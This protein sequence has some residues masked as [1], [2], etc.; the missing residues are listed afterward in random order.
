M[1]TWTKKKNIKTKGLRSF[2]STKL[3]IQILPG[4]SWSPRSAN[5]P[6]STGKTTTAAQKNLSVTLRT[7]EQRGGLGEEPSGFPFTPRA[8][9][10]PQGSIHKYSWERA[11]LLRVQTSLRVQVRPPL[12]LRGTC[13]EPS[14]HRNQGDACDRSL[15]FSICTQN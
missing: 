10:L 13:P 12:L 3:H 2:R 5:K 6:V 1:T 9:H 11:S 15:P 14:G 8:N 4:E 7:Q